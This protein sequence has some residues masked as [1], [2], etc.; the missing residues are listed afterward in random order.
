MASPPATLNELQAGYED[1]ETRLNATHDRDQA[2]RLAIEAAQLCMTALKIATDGQQKSAYRLKANSFLSKAE[3]IKNGQQWNSGPVQ[4]S[5]SST[6][7]LTP[8]HPNSV[9]SGSTARQEP[10]HTARKLREPLNG[11]KL[12]I[13]EREIVLRASRLNGFKFPP[14]EKTPQGDLFSRG[15]YTEDKP[16]RL[17]GVQTA[18]LA[19]WSRA[20]EALPPPFMVSDSETRP[21]LHMTSTNPID[22]VQDV[23]SDCSVV[24][25]L[26]AIAAREARGLPTI[27]RGILHPFNTETNRPDISSNG[28]YVLRLNFNGAWRI[29][30]IDDMLPVCIDNRLIHTIDLNNPSLLWPALLEKAYLK[31]RGG[32]EFPGSN[33]CTDLWVLTGWIPEQIFLQE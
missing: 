3:S 19:S 30:T 29:V 32:Y 21:S 10:A 8:A 28:L 12:A 4:R 1:I 7:S 2:L 24:A 16:L 23:A 22:L 18:S 27:L 33:S 15:K 11:R 17:S 9:F 26:C 13:K 6:S 20:A 31:V 5:S 25:S 14:W